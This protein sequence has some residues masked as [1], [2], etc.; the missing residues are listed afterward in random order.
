MTRTQFVRPA[1]TIVAWGLAAFIV[2]A[3]LGP[4][5]LRPH[6]GDA[7]L[8]RFGAY[9]VTAAAFVVAY[10]KR[11][12]TIAIAAVTAAV[13]LEA[14]QLL[15]PGRDARVIDAITKAFGGLAGV[16]AAAASSALWARW[17]GGARA[18]AV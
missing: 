6:L 18:S 11:P 10:P 16:A 4:Q 15:I 1:A 17:R 12:L 8:E 3:T 7:R 9:F 13:L 5:N 14:G 2:Y